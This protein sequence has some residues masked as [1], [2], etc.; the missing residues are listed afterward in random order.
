MLLLAH[1]LS[2]GEEIGDVNGDGHSDWLFRGSTVSYVIYGPVS[3]N[4]RESIDQMA[5]LILDHNQLGVVGQK[6]GDIDGDAQTDFVFLPIG[7]DSLSIMFGSGILPRKPQNSD[8]D[9]TISI[10]EN[11][12]EAHVLQFDGV[13]ADGKSYGDVAVIPEAGSVRLYSGKDI[14][15]RHQDAGEILFSMT[16]GDA[17]FLIDSALS[18]DPVQALSLTFG[19]WQAVLGEATDDL[20]AAVGGDLNAD[21]RQDLLLANRAFVTQNTLNPNYPGYDIGR[22][23]AVF[24]RDISSFQPPVR[25]DDADLIITNEFLGDALFGLGDITGDGYGDFA[26]TRSRE[27]SDVATESLLIFAGSCAIRFG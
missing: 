11:L 12:R 26:V 4:S 24:G 16:A 18:D 15:E 25:R 9:G 21:G 10:G 2:Q 19:P 20:T 27:G 23:Y 6:L 14:D 5:N 13:D 17:A 7:G 3:S 8:I 1:Q 22:V